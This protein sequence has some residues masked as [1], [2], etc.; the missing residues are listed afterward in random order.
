MQN[1]KTKVNAELLG[2]DQAL[3]RAAANAKKQAEQQGTPYVIYE[4]P[5]PILDSGRPITTKP[6]KKAA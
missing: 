3:H 5:L 1:S 4:K 2:I 6:N